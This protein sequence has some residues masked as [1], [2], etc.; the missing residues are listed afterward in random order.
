MFDDLARDAEREA[1]SLSGF[2]FVDLKNNLF[3]KL[4]EN[5][6]FKMNNP[7]FSRS[8]GAPSSV[9]VRRCVQKPEKG[10]EN[11]Q[12]LEASGKSREFQNIQNQGCK[13]LDTRVYTHNESVS[14]REKEKKAWFPMLSKIYYFV[15]RI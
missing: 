14:Y 5:C 7:A 2:F 3:W 1:R 4:A 9:L 8:L 6:Y 11:N 10:A 15:M 12:T 13:C